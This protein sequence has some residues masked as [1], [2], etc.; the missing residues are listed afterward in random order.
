M[1]LLKN[2]KTK[3]FGY[4]PYEIQSLNG[5]RAIA[6]IMVI[7]HH[8]KE[9]LKLVEGHDERA[10]WFVESLFTGVDLF[11][12]LSG[13]LISLRIYE[14]IMKTGRLDYKTFY[15]KRTFRIFPAYY[16]YLIV[17][18]LLLNGMIQYQA[19]ANAGKMLPEGE[20]ALAALLKLK[21]GIKFDFLYLSN[22]F[23]GAFIHTWSLAVEEQ[24][25]IIFPFMATLLFVRLSGKKR[26]YA[27]VILY[28]LPFLFRILAWHN[29]VPYMDVYKQLHYRFD[30]LVLGVIIMLLYKEWNLGG[31]FENKGY[32]TAVGLAAVVGIY[33]LTFLT[34]R[35]DQSFAGMVIMYNLYN[36]SM[37]ILFVMALSSKNL[38]V[39]LMS[40]GFFRSIAR[41][42]YTMYL[43][44][45][46][47]GLKGYSAYSEQIKSG[48]IS[49]GIYA[50]GLLYS[51]VYIFIFA[52]VLFVMIEYPFDQLKK[53]VLARNKPA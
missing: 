24:F 38:V 21:S 14:E 48:A 6:I 13:F 45:Y 35:R 51:F 42:S 23:E 52:V 43:W 7:I 32:R 37:A 1:R 19:A 26:L 46:V 29:D 25:Y 27:F 39:N 40:S 18:L 15:I 17:S 47:V 4:S 33:V 34:V 12:I 9:V 11:F 20:Q 10:F 2:I 5:L 53:R 22:Y 16:F 50:S 36:L 31:F 49:Y 30:S 44:H 8:S 41:L 28:I 3:I